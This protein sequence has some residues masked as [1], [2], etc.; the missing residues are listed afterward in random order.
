MTFADGARYVGVFNAGL[1]E[2]KGVLTFPGTAE[3]HTPVTSLPNR[4]MMAV[5]LAFTSLSS[6]DNS[7][8]EGDFRGGKYEGF[9]VYSRADGM[10]FKGQFRA[11]QV[12]GLC[13]SCLRVAIPPIT[14]QR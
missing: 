8:Y 13:V 10:N 6:A 3:P 5:C 14:P 11:G 4:A 2:G 7:K 12:Q 9:G 1:C